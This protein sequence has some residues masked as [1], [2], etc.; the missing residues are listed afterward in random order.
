MSSFRR[1]MLFFLNIL[2]RVTHK[3]V[4]FIEKVAYDGRRK[5]LNFG[6]RRYPYN[7]IHLSTS[8]ILSS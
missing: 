5:I 6:E 8:K 7:F 1:L 3:I 4:E 2:V